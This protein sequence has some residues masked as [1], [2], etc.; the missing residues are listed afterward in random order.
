M[1]FLF[2]FRLISFWFRFLLTVNKYHPRVRG[3]GLR[4]WNNCKSTTKYY[5]K[6]ATKKCIQP[7]N[8]KS[9]HCYD[10]TKTETQA[11]CAEH[12]PSGPFCP[13][14]EI[15]QQ[16]FLYYDTSGGS[17]IFPRGGGANSQSGCAYLLFL[18]KTAWKWKNLDPQ[19]G[20]ASLAPPLGS[21]NG[22]PFQW[23]EISHERRLSSKFCLFF[24]IYEG[25]DS[26]YANTAYSAP[27]GGQISR[28]R[29][30]NASA[31]P[32]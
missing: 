1:C 12:F 13:E 8:C 5:N 2:F 31:T 17:R 30:P 4:N 25:N 15:L 18:P 27:S 29:V 23:F 19:G 14:T 7:K 20:R 21:A 9:A 3:W 26:K 10:I 28:G 11:P 24:F 6:S 22:Y 32:T 16:N